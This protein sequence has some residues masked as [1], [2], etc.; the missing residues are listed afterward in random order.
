MVPLG[1]ENGMH[2]LW[3]LKTVCS[4]VDMFVAVPTHCQVT[5]VVSANTAGTCSGPWLSRTA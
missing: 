3:V 1:V 4:V 2:L 5:H